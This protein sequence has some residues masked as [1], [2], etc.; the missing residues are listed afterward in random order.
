M[1]D[2]LVHQDQ[3]YYYHSPKEGVDLRGITPLAVVQAASVVII[4]VLASLYVSRPEEPIVPDLT[5]IYFK[6]PIDGKRPPIDNGTDP[7]GNQPP[8]VNAGR[9]VLTVQWAVTVMGGSATDPEGWVDLFEWDFDGDGTYDWSSNSTGVAEWTY[10]L[11]GNY[12]AVFQ[13]TDDEGASANDSVPVVVL[14]RPSN[15]APV[16]YAGVDVVADQGDAVEFLMTGNDFDGSIALFEWDYDGDGTFDRSSLVATT[17]YH[18][19][20]EA[21]EYVANLRVTD[22]QGAVGTDERTVIVEERS[23]NQL[24][25]AET[26]PDVDV[27]VNETVTL[28]GAGSDVDG[29][30]VSYRWDLDGDGT[31]DWT[32]A[33][34]GIV[35]TSYSRAGSYTATFMVMDNN[36]TAAF[37]TLVVTVRPVVV[38]QPPV[39]D[40]GSDETLLVILGDVIEFRGTGSDADGLVVFHEW[41]F[42][43]DGVWDWSDPR[44]RIATWTYR[45]TG[46]YEA[47]FRVTD[48]EGATGVDTLIVKVSK[49]GTGDDFWPSEGKITI[50]NLG[51]WNFDPNDVVTVRPDIFAEN[52][53]SLFD[54]LVHLDDLGEIELEYH[55]DASKNTHVIDKI[56][57][58]GNWWYWAY[59]NGGWQETNNFRMDHYPYKDKMTINVFREDPSR[60]DR[61]HQYFRDEVKRLEANDGK[62][63][64]PKVVLRLRSRTLTFTDVEVTAHNLRNDTFQEGVITAI[65][66]ILS[67]TDQGKITSKLTWYEKIGQAEILN[68]FVDGINSDI[69]YGTCGF[70]YEEGSEK[71]R[72]G[73]HIHIPSD[74]RV[75]NSPDYEEWFWICL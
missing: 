62:V 41:D 19:F 49:S 22:D 21:G 2:D 29:W 65:D 54:I 63:I 67:L 33:T 31:Y 3:R 47:Q 16:A 25:T 39:A 17:T 1:L 71:L 66:V 10:G 14:P 6:V 7:S 12:T 46:Q 42:D 59:Y 4:L 58:M 5:D 38:N 69:A 15:M 57:G 27:F 8:T 32:S 43:G 44:E 73:N 40:A 75:L 48:N 34:T 56:N 64:V 60:I 53:F 30:I 61:I 35:E 72:F 13:A 28:T 20:I 9:D 74:Y 26:G 37:D 55:F 36:E 50:G 51:S 70:V 11:P 68:Y 45:R 24:P 18:I 52:H 23:L